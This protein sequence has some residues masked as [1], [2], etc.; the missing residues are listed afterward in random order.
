MNPRNLSEMGR[1]VFCVLGVV[2]IG[3]LVW[4][5][6]TGELPTVRWL[7]EWQA[8]SVGQGSKAGYYSPKLTFLLHLPL[9]LLAALVAYYGAVLHDYLT[10]QGAFEMKRQREN[11]AL[12]I[13]SEHPAARQDTVSAAEHDT[14]SP[15]AAPRPQPQTLQP[16]G[17]GRPVIK[18]TKCNT[19]VSRDAGERLPPWCPSCGGE[20]RS[21]DPKAPA[22]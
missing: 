18:C 22:N 3:T 10:S 16:S 4:L 17:F 7:N 14:V 15:I 13:D 2:L 8:G 11:S 6:A 12:L 5:M 20:L 21:S 1:T 9:F 19:V